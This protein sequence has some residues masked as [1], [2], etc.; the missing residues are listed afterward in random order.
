MRMG[1]NSWIEEN[2]RLGLGIKSGNPI[3]IGNSGN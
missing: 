3:K 2:E 1:L